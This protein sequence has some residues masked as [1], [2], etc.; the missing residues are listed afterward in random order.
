MVK[1]FNAEEEAPKKIASYTAK[2]DDAQMEKL[3]AICVA[4]GWMPFE[5]AYTRFAFKAVR[6]ENPSKYTLDSGPFTVYAE[7]QFLGEGLSEPI[8]SA[9]RRS[10][11]VSCQIQRIQ[12]LQPLLQRVQR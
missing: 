1:K 4:R 12:Q 9:G 11:F 5:V 10:A 8:P 3:R 7:G 2:L 6:L